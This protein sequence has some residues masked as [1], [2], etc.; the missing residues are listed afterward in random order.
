MS[1]FDASSPVIMALVVVRDASTRH[2]WV[3]I[4]I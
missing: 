4:P 1:S 3:P 2:N